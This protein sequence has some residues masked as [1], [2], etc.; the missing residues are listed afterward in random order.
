MSN[1]V[2]NN[3]QEMRNWSNDVNMQS[4][5]YDALI[6]RLYTLIDGFVNSEDFKG[7]LSNEFENVVLNQKDM[8]NS[9]ST[10]FRECSDL[11]KTTSYKIDSDR[12]MLSAGFKSGN[13]E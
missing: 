11:I 2:S 12:D 9:F 13:V 3:S 5:D 8:F 7:S 10:T 6:K 1:A 4:D